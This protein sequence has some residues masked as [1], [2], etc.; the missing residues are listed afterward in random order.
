MLKSKYFG[1]NG[2]YVE[3]VYVDGQLSFY[4]CLH[5]SGWDWVTNSEHDLKHQRKELRA[6]ALYDC[7]VLVDT[8]V[9]KHVKG[10]E[11]SILTLC[12]YFF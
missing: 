2:F 10:D 4:R 9:A 6:A 12:L 5:K 11:T 7:G 8:N 1:K 3:A